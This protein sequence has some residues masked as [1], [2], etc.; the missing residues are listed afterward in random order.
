MTHLPPIP[1]AASAPY[2]PHPAPIPEAQKLATARAEA[3]AAQKREADERQQRVTAAIGTGLGTALLFGAAAWG[4]R[5]YLRRKPA[6]QASAKPRRGSDDKSKRGSR[7]RSRVAAGEQYEVSYFARK[8]GI[9]AKDARAIIKEA[10]NDRK[11]A[12][13]L[14]KART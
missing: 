8:H 11:A 2:P 4:L 5:T 6:A 12:N 13:E 10:G 1:D 7:D 3:A 14:A 9:S